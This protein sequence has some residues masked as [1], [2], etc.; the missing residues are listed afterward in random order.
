MNILET[1]CVQVV[2]HAE[3]CLTA[4]E[5][6]FLFLKGEYYSVQVE[7][8]REIELQPNDE[9]RVTSSPGVN[10]GASTAGGIPAKVLD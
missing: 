1:P 5:N 9:E 10:A 6:A 2:P 4:A 7:E 3:R 8:E